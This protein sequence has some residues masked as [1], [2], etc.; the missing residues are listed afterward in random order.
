MTRA[1]D[2]VVIGTGAAGSTVASA[3]AKAGRKVAIV[4]K[5]PFGGTC[6]LRGCDPKKVLVG[7]EEIVHRRQALQDTGALRG[8]LSIEWPNLMRFKRTFTEPVPAAR[9][10]AY[11]RAGIAAF[12]GAARFTGPT[13]IAINDEALEANN[14][15]IAAGAHPVKLGIPGEEF[16]TTSDQFLELEAL[17]QRIVFI[18]GG[19]ISF[20]FAHLAA[21]SGAQATILHRG[22]RPLEQ[23]DAELVARLVEASRQAGIAI[24]VRTQVRGIKKHDSTFVVETN[25]TSYAADLVVHGAGRVAEIEEL[26]VE[27]GQVER[28]KKGVAVNAFLQSASNPRVYAAGDAADSGGLPLTPVA[29]LTGEIVAQNILHGN[30]REAHLDAIPSLVFT[31]PVLAAVGVSAG[32]IDANDVDINTDDM[33]G[34]Y[35]YRRTGDRYAAFKVIVHKT[36]D[37]VLGAHVLGPGA[38]ELIN[39]LT[40]AIVYRIPASQLRDTVFAYPTYTSDVSAMV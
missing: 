12:H 17:P 9:E 22:D 1:F 24:D 31:N 6:Q 11:Q 33:S 14:I 25:G 30:H 21:R 27:C 20:E 29:T 32:S 26:D 8:T 5:R 35:S 23:F 40:L 36:E 37:R 34:W 18:G 2:V 28:G 15:V 38:E 10:A 13:T 39:V 16:I 19:Y 3:C 7:A 4:D